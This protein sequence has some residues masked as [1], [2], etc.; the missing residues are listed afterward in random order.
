[1][2]LGAYRRI[3]GAGVTTQRDFVIGLRR[4]IGRNAR[5]I[6]VKPGYAGFKVAVICL[7]LGR[8]T[9]GCPKHGDSAGE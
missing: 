2:Q 6:D 7:G 9:V 3:G 1:M 5:A 8:F 4:V